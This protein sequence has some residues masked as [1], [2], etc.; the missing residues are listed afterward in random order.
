M[1][2]VRVC[3]Q[4]GMEPRGMGMLVQEERRGGERTKGERSRGRR[5][6]KGEKILRDVDQLKEKRREERKEGKMKRD[7][8]QEKISRR[9]QQP[10]P[11]LSSFL[12]TEL[13]KGEESEESEN[14]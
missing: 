9:E 2:V 12:Q 4:C 14:D 5:S 7:R 6:W 1:C 13:R 8:E 10:W 3:M 11:S